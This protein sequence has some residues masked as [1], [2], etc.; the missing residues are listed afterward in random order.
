MDY[1]FKQS[2]KLFLDS[3]ESDLIKVRVKEW[4][5]C[6]TDENKELY[7]PFNEDYHEDN[8]SEYFEK[9]SQYI[10][11]LNKSYELM[12]NVS[13]LDFDSLH[14]VVNY[15]THDAILENLD[16]CSSYSNPKEFHEDEYRDFCRLCDFV[17]M[18]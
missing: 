15:A 11:N 12:K 1:K 14:N 4:L 13:D 5:V 16:S 17:D 8:K 2:L 3:L 6:S 9:L 18:N 10:T 7:E